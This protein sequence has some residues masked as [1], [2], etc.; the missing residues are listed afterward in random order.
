MHILDLF[1]YAIIS[2]FNGRYEAFV[3]GMNKEV[4]RGE[5]GLFFFLFF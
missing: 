1:D 3:S 5:L 2:Y 4:K